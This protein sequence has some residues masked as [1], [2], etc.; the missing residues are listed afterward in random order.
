[1][2]LLAHSL[3]RVGLSV[4][5][6]GW[7]YSVAESVANLYI[8]QGESDPTHHAVLAPTISRVRQLELGY[9]GGSLDIVEPSVVDP[10]L[11]S[12]SQVGKG[13]VCLEKF[14]R[15]SQLGAKL[16]AM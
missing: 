14:T 2:R 15:F 5:R 3:I 7:K 6:S 13:W 10:G 4:G 16:V 12:I 1:M 8:S 11:S 9:S